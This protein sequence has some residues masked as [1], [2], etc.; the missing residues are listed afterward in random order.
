VRY[1]LDFGTAGVHGPIE[2]YSG[3]GD[4]S[5]LTLIDEQ[6]DARLYELTGCSLA[7]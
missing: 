3:L 6:G 4:S 7:G 2:G 1:V 5:Q